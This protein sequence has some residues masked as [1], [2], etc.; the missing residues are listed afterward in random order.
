MFKVFVDTDSGI[1]LKKAQEKGFELISMPYSI[2]NELYYPYQTLEEFDYKGFY[3]TLRKGVIP[4]TSA[5]NM[6]EYMNYFE[7]VFASGNDIL[8][9]HFSSAMSASF[10]F[11]D[12]AVEELLKK[13]PERKFYKI[14]TL[15]ITIGSYI[16][17]D[18]LGDLY[19]KGASIEEM[20]DFAEKEVQHFA[21]Y[22]FADDLKFFRKSG[23][24]SGLASFFGNI[25]GIRPI[26]VID[27]TG[28]MRS[29]DKVKGRMKAVNYLVDVVERLGDHVKDYK[30]VIGH[31]DSLEIAEMVEKE[32]KNKFGEDLNTEIVIVN[33]TIGSHCGPDG[34]GVAFHA[35]H[36]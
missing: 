18:T 24:V 34:V 5:L 14:D 12:L 9:I 35:I 25:I 28:V 16:I 1:T 6:A 31:T 4:T 30:V 36:R 32:L 3:D 13:Y 33:P 17:V 19:Q 23:R 7:P 10:G 21:C 11:M 2:N 8:Y 29:V 15:M 22:F 26:I 27:E 20:L